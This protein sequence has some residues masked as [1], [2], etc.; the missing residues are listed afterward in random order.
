VK[1]V[2]HVGIRLSSLARIQWP[3]T[4]IQNLG[5]ISRIVPKLSAVSMKVGAGRV[6]VNYL[7]KKI[8]A[9]K[10]NEERGL[11]EEAKKKAVLKDKNK[12]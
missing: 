11:K 5:S 8:E 4:N 10:A 9:I 1:D 12:Y 6:N 7:D 2:P 3:V